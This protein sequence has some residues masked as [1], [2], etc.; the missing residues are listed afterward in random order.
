MKYLASIIF[1]AVLL[2][3][4]AI[5]TA[6]A[7]PA[8]PFSHE[9]RQNDNSVFGARKWGDENLSGWETEDGFTILFDT[10]L[11]SWVYAVHDKNEKLVSSGRQV[12]KHNP[13]GQLRKKLRPGKKVVAAMPK[14]SISRPAPVVASAPTALDAPSPPLLAPPSV[15]TAAV[16][17]ILVNFKNT[18]VDSTS[19]DFE[20]L[21]FGS[22][23]WSMA[24]YYSEVSYGAFT[25]SSG[26][27]GVTG[28][29][30][31]N[32]LHD[33]YGE[34][35]ASG[36]DL[37]P[38]D[39]VYE[40]V[41]LADVT[42]DFAPYDLDGDCYVDVVNIVHQGTGEEAGS[43]G[44]S[45]DI[46][47]HSWSLGSAKYYGFGHNGIFTTNDSC[48]ADPGQFVKINSYVIQPELL[49]RIS[50]NNFIRST[51]G[52]FA[53]E[54]GHALGLPDLYDYDYSSQGIGNW[55]LMAGG[56]WNGVSQGGDR[57]AHLDPWSRY[58]L[59]WSTPAL[60]T[61]SGPAKTLAA[62][63]TAN[64]FYRIPGSGNEY[65]LLENRQK[66]GFDAGLPAAGLL[67]WHIDDTRTDNDSE[68]YPGC[69]SCTS[70][71]RVS[72]VQ[73]DGL[74]NLE[75]NNNG[76][77][78][79][80]PFPGTSNNHSFGGATLPA[81]ALY[82][83]TSSG[84]SI[85]DISVSGS[86]MTATVTF[87][88]TVISAAPPGLTNSPAA[89]INFTSPQIAASFECKLDSGVWTVCSAPAVV[90][91]LA[92]GAHTFSVRAKDSLGTLDTTPAVT[93]WTVDSVSPETV[94]SSGPISLTRL[95]GASF[96]FSSVEPGATFS[97]RLDAASWTPCTTPASYSTIPMGG[98]TFEVLARDL[99]GN[100]DPTPATW[101]WTVTAGDIRVLVDGQ[102]ASYFTSMAS[103][104]SSFPAGSTPVLS[105]QALIYGEAID[106][107]RCGEQ[108][109]LAGGYNSDFS[110]VIG[111][112]GVTG[113]VI[114]NCGTLIMD[115]LEII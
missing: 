113:P 109:T 101:N 55:S 28:W 73:A 108:V 19:A 21:L 105:L 91:S 56:S 59:G 98:H 89:S 92:D 7:V 83:S 24:D 5:D 45:T 12:G 74:Y 84:F 68:W 88:D 23:T 9:L 27:A 18:A 57:P 115:S 48:T 104:F 41:V 53:H 102:P 37:W 32:K 97:C 34:N 67:V 61:E 64:D 25:V 86:P 49:A 33:Y 54:Y 3:T 107:N 14:R 85:S 66:S 72:L 90:S 31:V 95:T 87:T 50:T 77:D 70:H 13:P 69:T 26:P 58:T 71:Y 42:V 15:S 78:G 29:V 94:I 6:L 76:G 47:S 75:K 110:A 38:G 46:W 99:A 79:G 16:P 82:S 17:V 111:R 36:N 65:F 35:N 11:S 52:V 2:L 30:K 39:L 4:A 1:I 22:G 81:A 100:S 60:L 106:I 62:V 40:A 43:A 80:D 112:T 8:A 93:S 51:V 10:P 103:A 114:V 20:A 96:G 63:E 44:F